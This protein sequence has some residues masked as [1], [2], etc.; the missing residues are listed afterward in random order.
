MDEEYSTGLIFKDEIRANQ[1]AEKMWK[2]N[3]TESQRKSGWC[4]LHYKVKERKVE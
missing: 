4:P 2:E 3:T 1:E